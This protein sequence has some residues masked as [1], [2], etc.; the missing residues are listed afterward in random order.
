MSTKCAEKRLNIIFSNKS[1]KNIVFS[2]TNNKDI[3][4]E[5]ILK[6][7]YHDP[8]FKY[9]KKGVI[10]NDTLPASFLDYY[11]SK[12]RSF[13]TFYIFK[14]KQFDTIKN[15]YVFEKKY[16]SINVYKEKIQIGVEGR[17]VLTYDDKRISFKSYAND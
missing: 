1:E 11:L 9:L 15:L 3:L 12:D 16:D 6:K 5:V 2:C 10:I 14:I 7:N 4:K 13:V 8:R 17:N